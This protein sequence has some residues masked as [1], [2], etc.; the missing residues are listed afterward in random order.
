MEINTKA[1]I[2]LVNQMDKVFLHGVMV[3]YMKVS[4]S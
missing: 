4:G 3:K 1:H 2:N